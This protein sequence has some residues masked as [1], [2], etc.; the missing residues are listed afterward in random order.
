MMGIDGCSRREFHDDGRYV[1]REDG[2]SDIVL[3]DLDG[4]IGIMIE[5]KYAQDGNMERAC[6]EAI[7]RIDRKEYGKELREEGCYTILKYGIFCYR[8]GC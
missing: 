5:V 6:R 7:E 4:A 1:D 3:R 8:K 2:Y